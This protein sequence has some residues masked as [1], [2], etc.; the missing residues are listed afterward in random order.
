MITGLVKRR[1][2]LAGEMQRTQEA[3]AQMVRD[4]ETLDNAI[5]LVAPELDIPAIAPRFVKPPADWSR[6]GEMSRMVLGILRLSQ[7]P[8]TSREVAGRLIVER[9]LTATPQLLNKMTRRVSGC[10]R[11]QRDKGRVENAPARGGLYLEWV[12]IK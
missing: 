12:I 9:G 8:L 1:A 6:R 7:K 4:M 5:R 10:L 2:E 11:E 3:L